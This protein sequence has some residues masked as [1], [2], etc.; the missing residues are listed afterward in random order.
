[1]APA[2]ICGGILLLTLAGMGTQLKRLWH[3]CSAVRQLLYL[4]WF[5]RRLL[6]QLRAL[7]LSQEDAPLQ[8]VRQ[9]IVHLHQRIQTLAALPGGDGCLPR[10]L[11]LARMLTADDSPAPESMLAALRRS[12][13]PCTSAE[14]AAFPLAVTFAWAEALRKALNTS[15]AGSSSDTDL[16]E[17]LW[18]YAEH[19]SMLRQL[20]WLEQGE[21]ADSLHALLLTEPS[22]TYPRMTPPSRLALRLD[23]EQFARHVHRPASDVV[24]QALA[25]CHAAGPQAL[26]AYAGY[27]LQ[28][29]QGMT[30]LHRSLGARAGRLYA[31]L[32]ARRT[33]CRYLLRCGAGVI[34]GFAFLQTGHPVFMLPFFSVCAGSVVRRI[35]YLRPGAPLP[36]MEPESSDTSF[37]TLVVLPARLEAPY[38]A[39]R[40]VERLQRVSRIC[41]DAEADFLLL[42]DLSAH[43]TAIG[44]QDG[45]I[46]GAA[47]E[48]LSALND[49]RFLYL[50][51]G[52][53]WS[54]D[55]HIYA[56]RGGTC[57]ALQ[58]V[59]RL[60]VRGESV[61]AIS[62][63]SIDLADFERRYAYLLVLPENVMPGADMLEKMLGTAAHPM[64]IRYPSQR[65]WRGYAVLAPENCDADAGCWLLRPDA[66]LE[67]TEDYTS[68]SADEK[69]LCSELAGHA[70]VRGALAEDT[71]PKAS[72][73]DMLH[74]TADT[75]RLL[76][77]QFPWVRTPVGMIRN[78][79]DFFARFRLRDR[80][81]AAALPMAQ[82]VLLVWALLTRSWPLLVLALLSPMPAPL[83]GDTMEWLA[84]LLYLPTQSA[85]SAA[86]MLSTWLPRLAKLPAGFVLELWA[87]WI[88]A[89][90]L[91]GLAIALSGVQI[92]ALLLAAG[93]AAIPL[94]PQRRR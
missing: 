57:G 60:I 3:G 33:L 86:G 85:V 65:G 31:R 54:D 84:R 18:Q 37:R 59:C 43:I 2:L 21:Q 55:A 41:R 81:R 9:E 13:M 7:P 4:G 20:H 88:T 14:I 49:S 48:A 94:I 8:S 44:G 50:Q 12:E 67:A 27:W 5:L 71:R 45:I 16:T 73:D 80:L 47:L 93:F 53:A 64:N 58:E 35:L 87:Q 66:F 68:M 52:R 11:S 28:D 75:W 39:A 46:A 83:A 91:V 24:R 69:L 74:H 42:G 36:A 61:D 78:P 6:R 79:L 72:W 89:S 26:E 90:V 19:F 63:S 10:M 15:L 82:L 34:A 62:C 70:D 25:L 40:E 51:R 30:Q 56:C 76:P 22:G 32:A 29:A 23:A 92:P 77:W 38:D 17:V 1:M